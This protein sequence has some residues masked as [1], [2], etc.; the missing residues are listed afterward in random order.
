MC[1]A[2]EIIFHL[3][4][5]YSFA[6]KETIDQRINKL[7]NLEYLYNAKFYAQDKRSIAKAERDIRILE[8]KLS[9][10]TK[11]CEDKKDNSYCPSI[12]KKYDNEYY[13]AVYF[14]GDVMIYSKD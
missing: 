4:T 13:I 10:I 2:K 1:T 6:R 7:R 9:I 14:S 5:G 8:N 11:A 3:S 12:I